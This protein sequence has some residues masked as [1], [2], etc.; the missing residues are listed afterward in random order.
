M[1]VNTLDEISSGRFVVG[2]GSGWHE[3]EFAA[4]GFNFARR[5]SLFEESLKVIV[6]LL[7]DGKVDYEGDLVK[8][9]ASSDQ[10]AREPARA[11]HRSSSRAPSH[12]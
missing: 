7:R 4:F 2:L 11:D 8:G 9:V 10:Q 6:P 5:V 12:A 1:D 3:P